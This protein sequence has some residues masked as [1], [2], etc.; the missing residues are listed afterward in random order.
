MTISIVFFLF[1]I[2]NI[3][4][5]NTNIQIPYKFL[6]CFVCIN[7]LGFIYA[8]FFG[9]KICNDLFYENAIRTFL[10][11][12]LSILNASVLFLTIKKDEFAKI[13]K[14]ILVY[15]NIIYLLTFVT[16]FLLVISSISNGER[17]SG[18]STNPNQH[19]VL[20]VT[21]PFLA[22]YLFKNKIIK[23]WLFVLSIITSSFLAFL[24]ES[25]AVY[26]SFIIILFFYFLLIFK[27]SKIEVKIFLIF[28]FTLIFYFLIFDSLMLYIDQTNN[29]GDQANVRYVLWFNGILAFLESPIIGFGPGSFSGF[30]EPFE[31]VECHNTFI[32][33]LTNTGL[34]GLVFYLFFLTKIFKSFYSK[35]VILPLLMLSS[36]IIYSLFHNILRHPTF[37]LLLFSLNYI[38]QNTN[39]NKSVV[40]K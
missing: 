15:F 7:F 33:L 38:S 21:I 20:L 6:I 17:F 30:F 35:N 1:N 36:I 18:Y 3:K 32:D 22:F 40:K 12:L 27:K 5:S 4:F 39:L 29:N 31:S 14:K 24:I 8:V 34:L 23:N 25:D 26:Y 28:F 9:G 11:Y 19:G 10:A 16:L 13:L 37:W 2:N